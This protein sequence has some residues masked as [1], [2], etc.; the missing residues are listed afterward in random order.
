[1][2][3]VPQHLL[4]KAKARR[5]ALEGKPAPE[6]SSAPAAS[7]AIEAAP[8]AAPAKAAA[9]TAAG[10][11]GGGAK[12]PA[13]PATP[14]VPAKPRGSVLARGGAAF[15]LAVTPLWAL[16]MFNSFAT[17][18]SKTLTP[19]AE[20]QKIYEAQCSACHGANGA[21]SDAGAPGRP[22]WNGEVEKTFPKPIDQVAFIKH[23]SCAAGEPYGNPQREGGQHIGKVGMP[24]FEGNLTDQ[25]ILYVVAYERA[26]LSGKEF[27]KDLQ[28]GV[29]EEDNPER[30]PAPGQPQPTIP[31]VATDTVCG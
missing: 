29:G 25:Q 27:P 11:G 1:V 23:G 28:A 6:A 26:I 18:S 2:A 14:A 22:L 5:A 30:V 20:G 12:V 24:A 31:E 21:G 16:F 9:A 19:E 15:F 4:D 7:T 17:P 8:A 10:S 13:A 3:G